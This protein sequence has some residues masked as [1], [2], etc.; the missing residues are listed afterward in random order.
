MTEVITVERKE[1]DEMILRARDGIILREAL[2]N[3]A[4]LDYTGRALMFDDTILDS[5]FAAILPDV[6]NSVIDALR[7]EN[8]WGNSGV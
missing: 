5:V 8:E 6:Y 7:D 2:K 3:A 1:Y 4:K